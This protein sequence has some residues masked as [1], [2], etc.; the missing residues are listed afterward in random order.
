M[1]LAL[2]EPRFD[3]EP[4]E[5]IRGQL[6]VDIQRRRSDPS[7]MAARAWFE[8]AFG[9]HPYGR[10]TQGSVD[11]IKA[12]TVDQLRDYVT[13]RLA[14]DNL[15]I[16]VAGDITAEE[17]APLL[18]RTFGHLP[19]TASLPALDAVTPAVGAVLVQRINVPQSVVTLGLPGIARDDPDYYAAYVANYIIGGGGFASR[20]TEEVREKRG[21]AYSV[22]SYLAD[23]EL[24]PLW[25]GGVATKNEQVAQSIDV[26]R[27]ELARMAGGDV[28]EA[29]LANAKTYLTG[30]FP[31][32]LHQQRAGGPHPR[33]HAGRRSGHRLSR[34][35]QRADR[36]GDAG[37]CQAGERAA[38]RA[39]AARLDRRRSR[40]TSK[41]P[42]AAT[43]APAEAATV[44]A[45]GAAPRIRR[46][47]EA[48]VNR[49]AAG[50]VVER[51]ASAVKE[52]VENAIDAGARR[53]RIAL[54]GAGRQL[55]RVEDDGH[56]MTAHELSL[57]IERHAT[58]KLDDDQ[59][60]D[61]RTLGFR[62]EALPSIGSVSRLTLTSRAP[63]E[64]HGWQLRCTAGVLE[65][66][67]PAAAP[68]GTQVEV[69]DL[70]FNTPARLKFLKS[71]RREVELVRDIVERLAM[72]H[73]GIAF[74]LE[75]EGRRLVNLPAATSAERLAA[76]LGREVVA[77]GIELGAERAASD[78]G[79]PVRLTGLACLP[80]LSRNHARHQFLFVNGRPVQDRLLKGALK[81]AYV[82]LIPHD[83]QPIAA[84]FLELPAEAVDVNVHPA[85]AEVRFK[86]AGEVRGLIVG[87]L[88]R[89]LAEHGHR[90]SASVAQA[91]LGR[92]TV[93]GSGGLG[94]RRWRPA[95]WCGPAAGPGRGRDRVAG[96]VRGPD[97]GLRPGRA[98]RAR[99]RRSG[100][101]V[102]R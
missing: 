94:G 58:S 54:E 19:A 61:I 42:M 26:I 25:M 47:P 73:P 93:V 50:E 9:A 14:R 72:A 77:N 16:G 60:V 13:A 90:A 98:E 10:T 64:A 95:S 91:A 81:A 7:T 33:R 24:S 35:P 12:I 56:G 100:C 40:P 2:A 57:A 70:F 99:R 43:V 78:G 22:Y 101:R 66:P 55:I 27:T 44:Q 11:S 17:L 18:D 30:S 53:I 80:T 49:I 52:L 39:R 34:P 31:L 59:L 38:L 15:I 48:L 85:K 29:D 32:A 92:F 84:L 79:Q 71:D 45:H 97:A 5:R 8:H 67:E 68:Q 102:G 74:T 82:D 83:R 6:V 63:S 89:A 69:L 36:G 51:P 4:V 65:P 21:L 3:A 75:S 20:L 96:A 76:L 86:D 46:L 62:G 41:P 37:R 1:R 88:K 23:T 87:G 28:G